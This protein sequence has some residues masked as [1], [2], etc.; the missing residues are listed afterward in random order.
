MHIR[1]KKRRKEQTLFLHSALGKLIGKQGKDN[2]PK[3]YKSSDMTLVIKNAKYQASVE[4]QWLMQTTA[5]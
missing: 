3:K 2:Y 1:C 4:T 5:I